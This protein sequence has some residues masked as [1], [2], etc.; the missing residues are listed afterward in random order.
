VV[1][2]GGP[3]SG[4]ADRSTINLSGCIPDG[5]YNFTIFD[6]Y[7]DG[8]CCSYGNGSYSFTTAGGTVLASGGSYG[9][10]ETTNFC[11]SAGSREVTQVS[12][13]K[14]RE[15]IQTYPN[16][17]RDQLTVIYESK[18]STTVNW[19]IVDL[20]GKTLQTAKWSIDAGDNRQNLQVDHLPAGT[21]ILVIEHNG[22]PHTRRFVVGGQ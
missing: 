3:Y 21:Y 10:S 8:M 11:L 5:C 22:E 17:A 19:R 13:Q 16:P 9:S 4:Q 18:E 20:L 15:T 7:G 12:R 14:A 2:S 1:Y 6:S